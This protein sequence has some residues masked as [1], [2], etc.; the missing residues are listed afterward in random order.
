MGG[1]EFVVSGRMSWLLG[2]SLIP[3]QRRLEPSDAHS[4]PLSLSPWDRLSP[5]GP[6]T[7]V[8][9]QHLNVQSSRPTDPTCLEQSAVVVS[10]RTLALAGKT[11][12]QTAILQSPISASLNVM[13][14]GPLI[15]ETW[16]GTDLPSMPF[17]EEMTLSTE[18]G[19]GVKSLRCPPCLLCLSLSARLPNS[20]LKKSPPRSR[21]APDIVSEAN[22]PTPF[23]TPGLCRC[24]GSSPWGCGVGE[25]F[26]LP[27]LQTY[28]SDDTWTASPH[29]LP[30]QI[31]SGTGEEN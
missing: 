29:R 12:Q 2:F 10:P 9:R 1:V 27:P 28:L 20:A 13:L 16:D 31:S 6:Q 26:H 18:G 24:K 21:N 11:S 14:E 30:D 5:V 23:F 3:L 22:V 8:W 7:L 15:P 25:T 4:V 19:W 17:L